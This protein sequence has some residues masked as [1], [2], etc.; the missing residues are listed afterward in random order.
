MGLVLAFDAVVP[1]RAHSL[2][3]LQKRSK[4]QS[5]I[6]ILRG[7]LWKERLSLSTSKN[8]LY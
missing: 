5:E 4:G 3:P 2:L 7:K 8:P 6:S 1:A